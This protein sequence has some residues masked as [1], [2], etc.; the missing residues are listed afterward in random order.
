MNHPGCL[1]SWDHHRG[2]SIGL[3]TLLTPTSTIYNLHHLAVVGSSSVLSTTLTS[4]ST[5]TSK[6]SISENFIRLP[7][8]VNII[9]TP[10]FRDTDAAG[11]FR[12]RFEAGGFHIN[13]PRSSKASLVSSEIMSL[14][15][16][17][18]K[19][20]AAPTSRAS[21]AVVPR[22]EGFASTKSEVPRHRQLA[23]RSWF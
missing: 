9:G 20:Q 5:P 4:M 7:D 23:P 16:R 3:T 1:L 15:L 21:S 19:I 14:K 13:K 12:C 17:D 8:N 18:T 2:N 10:K 22:S 6:I 11:L